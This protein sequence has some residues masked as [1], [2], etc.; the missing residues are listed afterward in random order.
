LADVILI[1][2]IVL[3]LVVCA[4]TLHKVRKVHL[5]TYDL[6]SNVATIRRET[7]ALFNQLQALSGLERKLRMEGPLP[8][9]R[10]WAASP[11][12]LLVVADEIERRKPDTV[13]EC[14]SGT[15][16]VVCARMLQ[17]TGKG[18]VYSL[19]H[20]IRYASATR[21]MLKTYRLSEWATVLDATLTVA[22]TPTPWYADDVIQRDVHNI[23]MLVIDGPPE[24]TAPLARYPALPRLAPRMANDAIVII[25]DATR[26]DE[27]QMLKR[28]LVEF[29]EYSQQL[30]DCEKGCAILRRSGRESKNATERSPERRSLRS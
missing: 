10:G 8:R 30:V 12:F 19:E 22:H 24:A 2:L 16:T 5:S 7:D 18:H 1:A 13:V 23:D 25:D 27:Q 26:N 14:S 28:W 15:S 29:P 21:E 9:M 4:L 11:D 20:D 6:T 3:L 17:L